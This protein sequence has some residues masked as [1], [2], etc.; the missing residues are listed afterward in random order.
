[1]NELAYF[2]QSKTNRDKVSQDCPIR[3]CFYARVSTQHEE[4]VNALDAQKQW[5][6]SLLVSHPN[7]VDCGMYVDKGLTGTVAEKRPDFMRMIADAKMQKFSLI[8]TREVCRFAR[9]TVDSLNITRKLAEMGVEVFFYN[10]NIWSLDSDGELRLTIMSAMAQEESRKISERVL[11]GQETSRQN[12][13]L[14]GNGNILGYHLVR[15]EKPS[16][17]TYIIDEENAETI[18]LIYSMYLQGD[19][20]KAITRELINR[21][22]TNAN[23]RVIWDVTRISRILHNKTYCG[24]KCYGKSITTSYL[25]HS[26]RNISD[27]KSYQYVKGDFPAIVSEED[28]EE[29]QRKLMEKTCQVNGNSYGK[30]PKTNVW[31]K[32][33][34]CSCGK[35]FIKYH[36]R[37]NSDHVAVYGFAC[38]NVVQNRSKDARREVTDDLEGMCNVKS[39]SQWKLE[40]MFLRILERVFKNPEKTVNHLISLIDRAYRFEKNTENRREHASITRDIDKSEKRRKSLLEMRLDGTISSE[41]YKKYEAELSERINALKLELM[42]SNEQ[43][44]SPEERYQEKISNISRMKEILLSITSDS[45]RTEPDTQLVDKLIQKITPCSGSVFKWYLNL[46]TTTSTKQEFI[47]HDSFT[48][49]FKEAR[50]YRKKCG[51]FLRNS[52][53][54]DVLVEIYIGV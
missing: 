30:R 20:I 3:I 23:G 8:V 31:K 27:R 28:W 5:L 44:E 18:R 48:I 17:N 33:L 52:Q 1:M 24:Y 10:D 14:Y 45:E 16:L 46:C 41:Y 4:Q 35:T 47:L 39:F 25:K 12:K 34:V 7:W 9:N 43:S 19:G 51:S 22:I 32:K 50:Q 37:T 2:K 42:E 40:Y 13:T 26:R 36:W 6:E 49:T 38:R 53:W 21:G 54:N 29:V 11:A 15:G